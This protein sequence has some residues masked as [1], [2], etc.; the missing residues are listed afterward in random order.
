M[1]SIGSI[2]AIA[3]S[4]PRAVPAVMEAHAGTYVIDYQIFRCKAPF[5]P[6]RAP[7]DLGYCI[8]DVG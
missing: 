5:F 4:V 3:S 8:R 6:S 7:T 2:C 1:E